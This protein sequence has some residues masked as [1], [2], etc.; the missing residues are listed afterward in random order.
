VLAGLDRQTL[1]ADRFEVVIVDDGS[2]DDTRDWLESHRQRAYGVSVVAQ[3]NGGPARARNRG[4]EEARGELVLFIDDDVEPTPELL[5]EHLKTHGSESDLV[6]MGP[7][8]SLEHYRQPWVKWEQEKL[9]AQYAAMVRGDYAPTFRQ[10][11]TGNASVGREH[12]LAAGGFDPTLPR[13]EDIELGRRLQERGLKFRFNPAARGLH[14]AERSLESWVAMHRYYGAFEVR[15]FGGLGEDELVHLL[16]GNWS[17]IHPLSRWLVRSCLDRPLRA[18]AATRVLNGWLVLSARLGVPLASSQVCGAL[19][20]LAYWS[21]SAQELGPARAD[22]VF[23]RGDSMR[24]TAKA[25]ATGN[26]NA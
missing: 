26:A 25:S 12:L 17:R 9:E 21:A 6:V 1:S 11:W 15:I 10:F 5:A 3:K 22:R 13:A 2:K 18:E 23:T 20:N 16:A 8:A 24:E 7:M 4:V 19:A 14:H